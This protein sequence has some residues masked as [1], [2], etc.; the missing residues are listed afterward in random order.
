MSA[1]THS[2]DDAIAAFAEAVDEPPDAALRWALAHWEAAAPR[3]LAMLEAY[4]DGADETDTTLDA[5][6]FIIHLCGDRGEQRAY[7]PLCRLMLDED[8]LTAALGDT[9]C[10]ETLKGV[11]IK[12]FDGDTMP[13]RQVIEATEADFHHPRRGAAGAGLADA[14]RTL[15]G[16][17]YAGLSAVFAE[18]NAAARRGLYLV[19]LGRG[20]RAARL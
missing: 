12:C 15:A 14:R 4:A 16:T 6:F 19:Q 20:R 2:V 17:G 11:L 8:K 10:V 18:G 9:A 1:T 7:R 5:L 3:F 13:L